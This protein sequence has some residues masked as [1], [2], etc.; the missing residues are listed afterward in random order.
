MLQYLIL[1]NF[2]FSFFFEYWSHIWPEH[3]RTVN[4]SVLSNIF[5]DKGCSQQFQ[6][7]YSR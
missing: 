5:T 3:K 6:V 2:F 4:D 7:K 1:E